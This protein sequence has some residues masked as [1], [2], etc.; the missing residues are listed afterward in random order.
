ML[1]NI[2]I[3]YKITFLILIVI[4]GLGLSVG[5]NVFFSGKNAVYE[6]QIKK[7][8]ATNLDVISI[9]NFFNSAFDNEY[10]FS[11]ERKIE[12]HDIA[13][14]ELLLI[15]KITGDY[16]NEKDLARKYI[17]S[18]VFLCEDLKLNVQNLGQ[19]IEKLG[20]T[21]DLGLQKTFRTAVHNLESQIEALKND[22]L[23]VD[24][25]M[26]RRGEKDF[27]ARKSEKYLKKFQDSLDKFKNDLLEAN[28]PKEDMSTL[29]AYASN[30][31][32]YVEIINK[33]SKTLQKNDDLS[34]K[35]DDIYQDWSVDFQKQKDTY[36]KNLESNKRNSLIS[37]T[38][39]MLITLV[40]CTFAIIR[41]TNSI[42]KPLA[43][44]RNSFAKFASGDLNHQIAGANRLDEI[45]DI[46]RSLDVIKTT[47]IKSVQ[48]KNGLN[49]VLSGILIVD[50]NLTIS[51]VNAALSN[52]FEQYHQQ[53]S[54]IF[55]KLADVK[56]STDHEAF[57]LDSDIS[58]F[59]KFNL[60][61]PIESVKEHYKYH[62]KNQDCHFNITVYPIINTQQESLGYVFEINDVSDETAIQD[63]FNLLVESAIRGDLSHRIRVV[64]KEGFMKD[65]GQNMNALMTMIDT[66]MNDTITL[67]F[68]LAHGNLTQSVE[69]DYEGAFDILK[70]NINEM[71]YQLTLVLSDFN[72]TTKNVNSSVQ[73]ILSGSAALSE[74]TEVQASHLEETAAAME[75]FSAT[76]N[77]NNQ[78]AVNARKYAE[79]SCE[80]AKAGGEVVVNAVQAMDKIEKS[81]R[82]ITDIIGTITDIAFQTNLL[83]LNAAIEASRAGEA[84]KGF[85]VVAE[86]VRNLAQRTAS[87]SKQIQSLVQE[88]GSYVSD[89][90]ALVNTTGTSLH[91]ILGSVRT[92]SG[93][94][95]E[96]ADA[97][98]EQS[99]GLNSINNSVS[100]IDEMTQ[101]NAALAR[102]T[103]DT[104]GS[105]KKESD[106]LETKMA[107]FKLK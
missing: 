13:K 69:K 85:S 38:L 74:R 82:Q 99:V 51:Y 1:N 89:G 79:T 106:V 90:V 8:N 26:C 56:N 36:Q 86:E 35:N 103:A 17:D 18:Y 4:V 19:L 83:A 32:E 50:T 71:I 94:I 16:K 80:I 76:I 27:I 104:M 7:L 95:N 92:L 47:G 67:F 59:N 14:R 15:E 75:E 31:K 68:Q 55:P 46:A 93:F 41:I 66:F 64:N 12:K 39:I 44:L 23:M 107:F 98:T 6:N 58:K 20:F 100:H 25:L 63:E 87:A 10:I 84:G 48:L 78:N 102:K 105:L 3:F 77:L 45:G 53:L 101:K 91:D 24:L 49:S 30:F 40:L 9:N 21:E 29:D 11:Q 72:K 43:S 22:K 37:L 81:S 5:V 2:K 65:L 60:D 96:I 34:K 33:I 62:I 28:M 42:T 54:D 70:Q 73:E 61:V 52:L 97:S 57:L 88:S